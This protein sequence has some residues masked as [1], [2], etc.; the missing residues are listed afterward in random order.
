MT[1]GT[2]L[3]VDGVGKINHVESAG[4]VIV[5]S[6]RMTSKIA[7]DFNQQAVIAIAEELKVDVEVLEERLEMVAGPVLNLCCVINGA[8][9]NVPK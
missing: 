5:G 8:G 2:W 6:Y 9:C 4:L 1:F 7:S 3:G